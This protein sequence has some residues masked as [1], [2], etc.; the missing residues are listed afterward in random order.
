VAAFTVNHPVIR[1]DPLFIISIVELSR[2]GF[3]IGL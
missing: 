1:A 3:E 2:T